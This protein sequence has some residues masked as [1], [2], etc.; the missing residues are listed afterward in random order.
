MPGES[1]KFVETLM[2]LLKSQQN[3]KGQTKNYMF[4]Y[5][6]FGNKF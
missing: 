2:D 1:L 5:C 3:Q 6:K 4:E